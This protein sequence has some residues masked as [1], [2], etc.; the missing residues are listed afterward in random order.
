[1]VGNTKLIW[2]SNNNRNN[3]IKTVYL[4]QDKELRYGN[5]L[6]NIYDWN[7]IG[8]NECIHERYN[9]IIDTRI[10][11]QCY[12]DINCNNLVHHYL[13]NSIHFDIILNGNNIAKLYDK[14][15]DKLIELCNLD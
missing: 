3:N 5:Y 13:V 6:C 11:N 12:D 9:C 2:M 10:T 4:N 7:V 14:L 1:M 15:Y 8:E